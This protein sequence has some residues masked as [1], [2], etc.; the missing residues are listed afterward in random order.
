MLENFIF[1]VL[2]VLRIWQILKYEYLKK[3]H[4]KVL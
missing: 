1:M 3:E 4:Q 2:N